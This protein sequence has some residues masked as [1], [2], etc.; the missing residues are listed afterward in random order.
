MGTIAINSIL[1]R[2]VDPCNG[3][4]LRFKNDLGGRDQIFFQHNASITYEAQTESTKENEITD[5]SLTAKETSN[6]EVLKMRA[7]DKMVVSRQLP[8]SETEAIKQL[9]RSR[10]VEMFTGVKND[11]LSNKQNLWKQ[12]QVFQRG[13]NQKLNGLHFKVTIEIV[14]P[15]LL[16]DEA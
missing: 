11:T 10:Y 8:T 15:E 6:I 2:V 14:L 12:V 3:V 7:Q 9:L 16:T 13:W 4:M 1:F 5:Y